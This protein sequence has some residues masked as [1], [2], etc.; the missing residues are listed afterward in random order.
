MDKNNQ[1]QWLD[2]VPVPGTVVINSGDLLEQWTNGQYQST[3]H[4]VQP[5][6]GQ[7]SRYSIAFFVDPD[8]AVWVEPLPAFVDD[9]HPSRYPGT[10]AKDHIL[11]KLN[12]SH[13]DRF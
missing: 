12:Q 2:A 4:R 7:R 10:T 6:T 1:N 9:N 3:V 8:D 13:K 11:K 5:V